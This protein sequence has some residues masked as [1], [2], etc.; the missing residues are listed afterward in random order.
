MTQSVYDINGMNECSVPA[1]NDCQSHLPQIFL[2]N[3]KEV[4][5]VLPVMPIQ[6]M[7]AIWHTQLD[8]E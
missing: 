4:C 6:S 8:C 2:V 5:V 1:S 7:S 3:L